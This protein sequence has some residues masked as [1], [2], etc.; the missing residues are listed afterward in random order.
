MSQSSLARAPRE[1]PASAGTYAF[2]FKLFPLG[3][4]T[5]MFDVDLLKEAIREGCENGY[6]LLRR[7]FT[8][9]T[10]RVLFF[11]GALGFGLMFRKDEAAPENEYDWRVTLYKTRFFTRTVDLEALTRTLNE[12]ASGGFELHFAIKYPT[13][14]LF[15]FPRESYVF[16]FRK[17]FADAGVQYRYSVAQT[18]Y[19]F[20]TRTLDASAYEADLNRQGG[21]GGL[22]KVSFRDERRV[23]GMFRQPTAVT[24]F[25]HQE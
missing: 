2:R 17:P 24:V 19:R 14:F 1:T 20:F 25:E 16:V 22:F 21:Q 3:L 12:A 11:L 4:I 10:R 6:K 9:E 23:F 13:R 7:E 15:F 5:G 8:L 18:P